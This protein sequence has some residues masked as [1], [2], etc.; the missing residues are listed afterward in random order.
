[1]NEPDQEPTSPDTLYHYC[2]VIG[3]HGILTSKQLWVSHAHFM[4]DYAEQV[5]FLDRARNWLD[6]LQHGPDQIFISP[7][8]EHFYQMSGTPYIWGRYWSG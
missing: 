4:N 3:F 7:L 1:M 6:E 8:I 5:W 2:P